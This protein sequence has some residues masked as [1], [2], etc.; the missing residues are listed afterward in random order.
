MIWRTL[1]YVCRF[2]Q[3]ATKKNARTGPI[4]VSELKESENQLFNSL[5]VDENFYI[6]TRERRSIQK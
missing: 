2:A 6:T 5:F 4:T 1:A 3:N